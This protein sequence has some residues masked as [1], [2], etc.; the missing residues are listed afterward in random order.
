MVHI[1]DLLTVSRRRARSSSNVSRDLTH[2][3]GRA[4]GL[5]EAGRAI[6]FESAVIEDSA[7]VDI[8]G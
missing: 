7:L 1:I 3:R 2:G 5:Q 4:L 6:T 8:A